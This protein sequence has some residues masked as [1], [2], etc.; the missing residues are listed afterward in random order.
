MKLDKVVSVFSG[1]GGMSFGFS[2]AGLKPSVG[3]DLNRDACRTYEKNLGVS[4]HNL[5]LGAEDQSDVLRIL[6]GFEKPLAVIGGPPCQG[7]STAGDRKGNDP[8]NQLIFNYL[9][10]VERLQP[11]W[12]FF[13][14]VEGLLTSDNG[15]SVS[16]LIR[17]FLK[18]GYSVRLEK[19]NF[20]A[21][22][23]PQSRK[24]VLIIGNRLGLDFHF[25]SETHSYVSGKHNYLSLFPSSPNLLE[26]IAG[27]PKPS[28]RNQ[29]LAYESDPVTDY[30]RWMRVGNNSR[31]VSLHYSAPS[32]KDVE[33]FHLLEQG[34]TMKDLPEELWHPSFRR[35]AFR[36]VADGTPTEKRGGAPSG[37]KRLRGEYSALTI[38]SAA[39]REFIHPCED[40]PLTIREA[41]RLQSF[42]DSFEFEG[43]GSS[44]MTQVGNAV[45]PLAAEFFARALLEWDGALG[46]GCKVRSVSKPKLLG[47]RLTDASGMSPALAE[48]DRL[49]RTLAP[50][51]VREETL[52]YR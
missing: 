22:G 25:P 48:T 2:R 37:I 46:S 49:L 20:A 9:A 41:A 11:R 4:S 50:H 40:R 18:I 47:F 30:D 3:I 15:R 39:N 42:P 6:E 23:L 45:P 13:E 36:R 31:E 43:N 16:E 24:R 38:T 32:E 44:V 7:F 19:V 34:Q 1:A 21:Y 33:R 35:R 29:R 5:D 8:R 14:N 12:F 52:A 51:L 28:R 26:A 17:C 27:L 10:L